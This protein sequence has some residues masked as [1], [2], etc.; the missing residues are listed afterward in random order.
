VKTA[1]LTDDN[2]DIVELIKLILEDSG[3]QLITASDGNEAASTCLDQ[4]HDLVLMDLNMP[5]MSGFDATKTLRDNGFSN[6]IVALTASE[7]EENR[8]RAKQ[9][10]SKRNS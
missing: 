3:Y 4:N 6:P 5:N 2:E 8:E 9:A 7:A 10:G 1:L